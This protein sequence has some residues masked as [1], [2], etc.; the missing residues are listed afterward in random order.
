MHSKSQGMK[1]EVKISVA[2]V[3]VVF[4]NWIH[5][6]CVFSAFTSE[7]QTKWERRQRF[8][9]LRNIWCV[10]KSGLNFL[11]A[12][13][14][15]IKKECIWLQMT[16][17]CCKRQNPSKTNDI[18][19]TVCSVWFAPVF[20]CVFLGLWCLWYINHFRSACCHDCGNKDNISDAPN[21]RVFVTE[22][23]VACF[24]V[25]FFYLPTE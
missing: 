9:P 15:L 18:Y 8:I 16:L 20:N 12:G 3:Y 23:G 19:V 5:S 1:F 14:V 2:K 22:C 24:G 7:G 4:M 25:L 11:L 10:L 6:F 17:H 13:C 21:V